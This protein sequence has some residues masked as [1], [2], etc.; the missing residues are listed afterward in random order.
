VSS[1]FG[2]ADS[3]EA[4]EHVTTARSGTRADVAADR[5]LTATDRSLHLS[6]LGRRPLL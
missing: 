2:D 1:T 6:S 4:N 3:G 5:R